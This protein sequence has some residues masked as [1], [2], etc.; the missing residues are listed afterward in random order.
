MMLL[1]AFTDR[2]LF[3][4][5]STTVVYKRV[6]AMGLLRICIKLVL[7]FEYIPW[8]IGKY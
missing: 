1:L 8:F 4:P 6:S 7:N 3:N 5:L 2:L